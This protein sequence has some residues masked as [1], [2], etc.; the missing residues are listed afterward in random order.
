[1]IL[2]QGFFFFQG[3]EFGIGYDS[4]GAI[5]VT[6]EMTMRSMFAGV[7]ATEHEGSDKLV[8]RMN[9]HYGDSELMGVRI[10]D[11]KLSFTKKYD[12][13]SDRIYYQFEKGADGTWAGTFVGNATGSGQ[14]RCVLTIVSEDFFLPPA[15]KTAKPKKKKPKH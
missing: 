6:R 2:I 8:G 13:R 5:A 1:M 9:D 3:R 12:H 14:A 7:I 10:G 4:S 15:V 11:S